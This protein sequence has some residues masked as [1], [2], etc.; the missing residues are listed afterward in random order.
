MVL[1]YIILYCIVLYCIILLYTLP[2]QER[3]SRLAPRLERVLAARA[4]RSSPRAEEIVA[5]TEKSR[6]V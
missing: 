6:N 5:A 3:I 4:A 1:Y 2:C